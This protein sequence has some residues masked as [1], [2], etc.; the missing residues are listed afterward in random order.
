MRDH[1]DAVLGQGGN[2]LAV[3]QR[4]LPRHQRVG[5]PRQLL[6]RLHC[7]LALVGVAL[8]GTQMGFSPHFK[9]LVQ[10]GRYDAQKPQ[11]L[12][13]RHVRAAGAVKHPCIESQNA[14]VAVQQRQARVGVCGGVR[15]KG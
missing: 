6:E 3:V 13:Q 7:E 1:L 8:T 11:S 2:E 14:V 12:Q 4:V 5:H 9:K 15:V 10:I